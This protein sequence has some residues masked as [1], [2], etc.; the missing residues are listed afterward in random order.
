MIATVGVNPGFTSSAPEGF[1]LAAI[2]AIAGLILLVAVVCLL[3]GL[4]E[5]SAAR[6]STPRR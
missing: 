5:P 4:N 6:Y 3:R 1:R 2:L